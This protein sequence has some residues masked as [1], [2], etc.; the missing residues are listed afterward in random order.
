MMTLLPGTEVQARGLR[1][2]VVA[3]DRLGLQTLYRLRCLEG[4]LRGDEIDLLEPFEKIQPVVHDLHPEKAAPLQNWLVYHQAF[5][6]EQALGADALLAVQPGRLKMEAYQLVPVLRA[7]RMSRVRLLLAD[8]VGLGKTIQAGLILTELM[9][10]RVAHRILIVSPAGPLL[11]QWQMEMGERFGL[12]MEVIDRAKLE[13]IRRTTELGA[14]PFDHIPLGLVSIDFL[15]QER[16][17][18]LLERA[19]YDVVVIDE[20]HHCMDLG[21]AQEREDSQRRRLAEVLARRSDALLLLTA[22]PHD[23]NDRSFASLCELLDPSLVDGKGSLRVDRYRPYV[24]R[25]LKNHIPGKFRERSVLPCPVPKG[26]ACHPAFVEFQRHLLELVAPQLKRAFR[27][28]QYSDVLSLVSLLKRSVSTVEACKLTLERISARKQE[29]LTEQSEAQ[30]LKKQRIKTLR[31]YQQKLE[32]F[33]TLSA[34]EEQE[35]EFLEVEDLARQLVAFQKE[36]RSQ[37]SSVRRLSEVVDNLDELVSLAEDAADYDPKLRQLCQEVAEIR[38]KEPSA[39]ILI[40]TEYVDSQRAVIQAFQKAQ[41]GAILT[42][43]G[44]D[45]EK[46][47]RET[48]ERFCA[49]ANLILVSTDTA[50][51]GLN[52][53]QRCHYLIH[54][55]LPFN[56]NRLEQ[57]NGRI[58]RFGQTQ[59]PIVRYLFLKGTFE[60]RILLRLIAKYER[61]RQRLT[62]V[63]NTLGLTASTEMAAE[64]LLKG[65]MDEDEKLFED[66]A[67]VFDFVTSDE[68]KGTDS[69]TQ[70]LLE[71]IDRSLKGFEQAARTHTWLGEMG[72][73]AEHRLLEEADQARHL[74]ERVNFVDLASFVRDAILLEGGDVSDSSNDV[75]EIQLPPAWSHGLSE[76]PGYDGDRRILRLTTNLEMTRDAQNHAVGYLGRAHPLVRRA[77]DRVRNLSFGGAAQAGYELRA[78]VVKADVASSTLLFT[79]LGRVSSGTGRELERVFAVKVTEQAETEFYAEAEQWLGL[80]DRKRAIRTTNVWQ[81]RFA[82]WGEAA[83]KTAEDVMRKEFQGISEA[84]VQSRKQELER[85]RSRH[86]EWLEQRTRE[87]TGEAR[88]QTVQIGLFDQG[89]L[90]EQDVLSNW[91]SIADAVERLAAF[92]ADKTQPTQ[93]RS[94]ADG[95]LRIYHQ[96]MAVLQSQ[97]NLA[98]PEIVLLGVLMLVPEG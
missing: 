4:H 31:D 95:V 45:S 87:I 34:D 83:G 47:R 29:I 17:L 36:V 23:G 37:S 88:E 52:L 72:M 66:N 71:E 7:I 63:P 41:V 58:D 25:R 50:A 18:D 55:E 80:A 33:G 85:E 22:T 24:V 73:N 43:C 20:A 15:K 93:A 96:R 62:F 14:N 75:F 57:R 9:A 65:L 3:S 92:H 49:E 79:F 42:M 44:E 40:F 35:K 48:T 97:L 59:D 27:T 2:E 53:Q 56:P 5:L 21:V 82:T 89:A 30:E 54:L 11:E 68:N 10:R 78:S 84:F 1:W 70:E 46:A 13:E 64:G 16:I 32:R 77:L 98:Q 86:V 51:E 76:L 60:E 12:R 6:L 74:G 94:E 67:P 8:G 26:E 39:N 28:K 91:M 19:S 90:A 38:A 81:Q 61:Q 69:A